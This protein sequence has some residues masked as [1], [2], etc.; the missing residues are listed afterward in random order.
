MVTNVEAFHTGVSFTTVARFRAG[1]VSDDYLNETYLWE[2]PG[3]RLGVR[4]AD[5]RKAMFDTEGWS[6]FEEPRHPILARRD[7]G[8]DAADWEGS[9]WLEARRDVWLWP[10]PPPG[11]LSFVTAWPEKG[12]TDTTTTVDAK[13][14]IDAASRSEQ[15]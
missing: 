11:Q 3:P 5:G 1:A 14:L 15:L 12:I 4:F 13:E 8:F 2:R 9:V 6:G 7:G 10:L